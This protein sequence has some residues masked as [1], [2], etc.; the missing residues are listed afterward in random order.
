MR[1]RDDSE[2][3]VAFSNNKSC[4][5]EAGVFERRTHRTNGKVPVPVWAVFEPVKVKL[6]VQLTCE[7]KAVELMLD[8]SHMIQR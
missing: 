1:V 6:T 3:N 4:F 2:E 8:A 7:V 5:T